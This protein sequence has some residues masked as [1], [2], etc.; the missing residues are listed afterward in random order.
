[1]GPL[2]PARETGAERLHR[3]KKGWPFQRP[4]AK[5]R[6]GLA[7]ALAE[8]GQGCVGMRV[9]V[10]V[11]RAR[12]AQGVRHGLWAAPPALCSGGLQ[13]LGHKLPA[14]RAPRE[15]CVAFGETDLHMH[16]ASGESASRSGANACCAQAM[17]LNAS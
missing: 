15:G 3:R 8:L 10:P 7:Q 6:R 1:M 4:V 13:T 11:H 2:P 9:R 17:A 16:R 12:K 14:L 5:G